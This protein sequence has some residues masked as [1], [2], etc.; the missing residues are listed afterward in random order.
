MTIKKISKKNLIIISLWILTFILLL[1]FVILA[2]TIDQ[3]KNPNV[4]AATGLVFTVSLFTSIL[5]TVFIKYFEN[6]K[7]KNA[8]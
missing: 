3:V 1:I 4:N 5:V 2:A 8:K 6:K 7:E